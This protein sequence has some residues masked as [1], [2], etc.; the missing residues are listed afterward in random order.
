MKSVYG[1]KLVMPNSKLSRLG[2]LHIGSLS[3]FDHDSKELSNTISCM[4]TVD[5]GIVQIL[6]VYGID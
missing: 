5:R 6:A 3:S 1:D 4:R 2:G